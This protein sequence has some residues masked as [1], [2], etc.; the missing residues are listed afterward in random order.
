MYSQFMMHG[1][2]NIKLLNR[3]VMYATYYF[4]RKA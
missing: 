2:Q 3:I 1:Q 4:Q